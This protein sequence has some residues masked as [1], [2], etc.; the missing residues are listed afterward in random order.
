[1]FPSL[2][3]HKNSILQIKWNKNYN[4]R[5]DAQFIYSCGAKNNLNGKGELY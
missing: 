2:S 5:E 1:M 3:G 4:E